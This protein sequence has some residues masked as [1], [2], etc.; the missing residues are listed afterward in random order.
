MSKKKKDKKSEGPGV[1]LLDREKEKQKLQP[2]SKYQVVF[3]NDDYTP[4]DFVVILLL[5]VFHQPAK[6]AIAIMYNIHENGRGIAGG[7]YSKEIAE[8]KL[9]QVIQYAIAAEHP[10]KAVTEKI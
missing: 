4:M 10:L 2:P 7:P 9:K 5:D 3:Y 6:K 1:D 8:T